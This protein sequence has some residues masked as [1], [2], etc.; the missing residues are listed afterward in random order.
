MSSFTPTSTGPKK[1]YNIDRYWKLETF[2]NLDV[3]EQIKN[4]TDDFKNLDDN[5]V[6]TLKKN[7]E[8]EEIVFRGFIK[9]PKDSD[10]VKQVIGKNGKWFKKTTLDCK[11]H[12][13]WHDYDT[14]IFYLWGQKYPLIKALNRLWYRCKDQTKK[15]LLKRKNESDLT[16]VEDKVV[17]DK[18]VEDKVVEDKVVEDNKAF[19]N[20]YPKKLSALEKARLRLEKKKNNDNNIIDT[21]LGKARLVEER[22][23]GVRVSKL[24]HNLPAPRKFQNNNDSWATLYEQNK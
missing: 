7:L 12:F 2:S 4:L 6:N 23:D 16:K 17:E 8:N 3:L 14:Q 15:K 1:I 24:L 9:P 22:T 18:V 20:K 13:I 21:E 10:I 11:I 19:D 5:F